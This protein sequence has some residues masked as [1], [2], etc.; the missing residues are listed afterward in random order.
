MRTNRII[1]LFSA[2]I[3][4]TLLVACEAGMDIKTGFDVEIP[5]EMYPPCTPIEGSSVD[6]CE[7][8]AEI[9]QTAFA[10]P[11]SGWIHDYDEPFSVQYHL[12]GSSIGSVSHIVVRG[13]FITDTARCYSDVPFST[14]TYIERGY[15]QHSITIECYVDVRANAY[16]LGNGPA[17]FTVLVSFLHYWSGYYATD[18]A[19]LGMTEAEL[20]EMMRKAHL[21][22]LELSPGI[23][24]REVVMFLGPAHNQATEAWE[25]FRM[26]DVQRLEDGSVI[27]VHP[28]RDAWREFRPA[29]YTTQESKL[30]MTLAGLTGKVVAADTARRTAYGG[31]IAPADVESKAAGATLPTLRTN[32]DQL[33]DFLR[34]TGAY[35]NEEEPP[36]PP[37]PPCGLSIDDQLDKPGLVRDCEAL[38]ASKDALRGTGTLNWAAGTAIASWDGV[39]VEGTPPR[40]TK[41]KLANKSL[42]GTIP[43][44]MEKLDALTEIKLAGNTL[45]GCIPGKLSSVAT[46]DLS[47][48]NLIYCAPAPDGLRIR[49]VSE[50]SLFLGWDAVAGATKYR[51]EYRSDDASDF[52]WRVA[53]DN[54]TGTGY[55][56]E[57]LKCETIHEV[58]VSAYGNG[59]DLEAKWSDPS[60][61]VLGTT[62]EC[63]P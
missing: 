58:R 57:D 43:K 6:P 54:I 8:D 13:T 2:L 45:T 16:M 5:P 7:P 22:I 14:P 55:E 31:K 39:T 41:L 30:E 47:S 32:V 53:S 59:A 12:E 24:G 40:V 26:W 20:V 27:A 61:G 9:K 51:V 52:V 10:S 19:N 38:L 21:Q 60:D 3:V 44:D 29:D 4:G 18:A 11:K 49:A 63:V 15:F 33:D 17:S 35:M 36:M 23:Y 1:I 56:P 50:D 34:D 48:L 37:P 62:G 25:L 46:N 42:T 28:D